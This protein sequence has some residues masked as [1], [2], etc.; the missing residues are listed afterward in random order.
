MWSIHMASSRIHFSVQ[1]Q[2]AFQVSNIDYLKNKN[3]GICEPD[4]LHVLQYRFLCW[5]A[6]LLTNIPWVKK[7]VSFVDTSGPTL[8]DSSF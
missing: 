6:M 4:A 2:L 8:K 7:A 5:N 3:H 1:S